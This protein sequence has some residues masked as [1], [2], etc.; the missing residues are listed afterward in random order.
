MRSRPGRALRIRGR[1]SQSTRRPVR[2]IP[3]RKDAGLKRGRDPAGAF[4][5]SRGCRWR[6]L[7][8]AIAISSQRGPR[9]FLECGARSAPL[10]DERAN[11]LAARSTASKPIASSF[12]ASAIPSPFPSALPKRRLRRRSPKQGAERSG[13]PALV[14]TARGQ[15][16]DSLAGTTRHP[17]AKAPPAP[18]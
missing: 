8:C 15:F 2:T 5:A 14:H 13:D 17:E 7:R 6:W 10:S 18:P 16:G 9:A 4:R 1:I 12:R 3:T 11:A